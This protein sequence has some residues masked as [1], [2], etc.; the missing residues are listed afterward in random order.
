MWH[1]IWSILDDSSN[2]M[3]IWNPKNLEFS[4][5]LGKFGQ[6]FFFKMRFW[7]KLVLELLK[8]G[9]LRLLRSWRW[10]ISI[11]YPFLTIKKKIEFLCIFYVEMCHWDRIWWCASRCNAQFFCNKKTF[12]T[13]ELHW[14][15]KKKLNFNQSMIFFRQKTFFSNIV[16]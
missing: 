11:F 12:F 1:A 16:Q 3:A 6:L 8:M 2:F 13:N 5:F 10:F 9:F 14:K 4:V 15:L 7:A